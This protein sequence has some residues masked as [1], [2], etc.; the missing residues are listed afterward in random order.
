LDEV[1]TIFSE[2]SCRNK[3]KV[4]F[5]LPVL[6]IPILA[7]SGSLP[8]FVLSKF[9]RRLCLSVATD[10]GDVKIIHGSHVVG[11]FP[12]GFKIK[13]NVC[14]AYVNKVAN[15]VVNRLG[16]QP[17]V[18]GAVHIFVAEKVDG[19]RL[20]KMLSSRYNCRFV[21]SDTNPQEMNQVALK[22][23]KGEFEVLIST[24]I[25]L[26]GNE[27]P[28]CKYLA[29]AGYL[30]DS[31]QIVQALGRLRSY[32]RSP[33]GQVLFAVPE[34]LPAFRIRDDQQ[35][36]TKLVNERFISVDDYIQY[37]STM[38]SEG[39]K[40]WLG[41][42]SL[43][44]RG[45]ALKN[46]SNYFGKQTGNCGACIYCRMIPTKNVQE[47]ALL[48]MEKERR[49]GQATERALR[50]LELICLVCN[51]IDCIGLPILKGKGSKLL[52]ENRGC[53]FSWTNCYRCG[54]SNHD[55]KTQC[56][57]KSYL[58]NIACCECWV[59]KNVP[60]SKRHDI[61]DCSVHGRL[62]RLLSHHFMT[63]RESKTFQEYIEGIYT[64]TKTFCQFF[65][66]IE[67]MYMIV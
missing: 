59:F 16:P 67:A 40:D 44:E 7:L 62:R 31:M 21:S 46:L 38:S 14:E 24:S 35:R 50:K 61:T 17:C 18:A 53:C 10:L 58:N 63:T 13:V 20:L 43:G 23:S 3:Y 66:T 28:C 55:R 6:G 51:R 19:F 39:V 25:A 8:L 9:A 29:C 12:N 64:S 32:M 57:D 42:A 37:K 1:H 45:C 54:V 27:N 56:F 52:P 47:A 26:V 41:D 48:R 33:T 49:N 30:Y 22:W 15:F 60:G 5:Q 65:A 4:Y 36:F 34:Q 11:S 2:L